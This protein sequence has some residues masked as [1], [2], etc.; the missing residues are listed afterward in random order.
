[1][2]YLRLLL[3]HLFLN[4]ASKAILTGRQGQG[5][6]ALYWFR[7]GLRLHDN[8]ALVDAC[9]NGTKQLYPVFCIDPWFAKPSEVGVN[10]YQFLLESLRD[11]DSSLRSLG[12]RLFV[13]RGKPEVCLLDAVKKWGVSRVAWELDSEPYSLQRD[14][15]IAGMLR[16]QYADI[17][18]V[19]S[20]SH[21][22]R[23]LGA[24]GA[25]NGDEIPKSYQ[26][27]V[28]LFNSMG[29]LRPEAVCPV[30]LPLI[31]AADR[32]NMEY[33]VPV[34]EEVGYGGLQPSSSLRGGETEALRRMHDLVT[35]RQQWVNEFS[36]PD[37]SPNA[38]EASTTVLSPYL[39]FGC[40]SATTFY[41]E[42]S[43]LNAKRK[44]TDPP[45]SLH[46]QLLWREFFY[47]QSVST[48]NFDKMVGN[49][50]CRQIPWGR[51]SALIEAWKFGR[52]GFPFID[53][54]MTQL[55]VEGWI[56]HLA[57]H[58]VACFLTRGDLW[59]HWEEGVKVFDLYLLD[60][61]WALNNAN[62]QWLSCSNFFYQYFRCYSP[63][64]FGKK[65]DKEGL[66]IKKW[67]PQ[68]E[69]M[70]GKFIYEPWLAPLSV[71]QQARCLIGKDYPSPIVD[72][73]STSK[74]NMER[75][76]VA[77][78]G[79]HQ[80]DSHGHVTKQAMTSEEGG[81]ARK[82][83]GGAPTGA[84]SSSGKKSRGP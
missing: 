16:Q 34:L 58:A 22:L 32:D 2:V 1:M 73:A 63:V 71:Q 55:R 4:M 42:L 84:S 53:A 61:D 47:L 48:V 41:N 25:H 80:Q 79:Y 11:L 45:V 69:H 30:Q 26:S 10:R 54:I 6:V 67:L 19:C 7:K 18:I 51:E 46:G 17:E 8:P 23:D 33:N 59:Q 3:V 49:P 27:F 78:A 31:S 56:H 77:Y 75:M 24:Y 60:S 65:T 14:S 43:R 5:G 81:R 72:H 70:P 13:L 64:A 36:K 66:Y 15:K 29:E 35:S 28:K 62:W 12:S 40:L 50:D 39:K 57:R 20:P 68:L 83:P 38:L 76:K 44:H 9:M 21:T 82:R 37:T 74:I 52:T